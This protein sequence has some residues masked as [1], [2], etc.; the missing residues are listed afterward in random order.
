M[1]GTFIWLLEKKREEWTHA[2]LSQVFV[3]MPSAKGSDPCEGSLCAAMTAGGTLAMRHVSLRGG[4][5]VEHGA[6]FARA[7]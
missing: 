6:N 3:E 4:E 5:P 1:V 2:G 7:H